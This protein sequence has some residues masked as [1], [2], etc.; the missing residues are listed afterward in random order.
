M[1]IAKILPEEE[2]NFACPLCCIQSAIAFASRQDYLRTEN[3]LLSL[4]LAF[5]AKG[6]RLLTSNA[7]TKCLRK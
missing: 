5:F 7:I 1:Y 4:P 6:V 2:T 3:A